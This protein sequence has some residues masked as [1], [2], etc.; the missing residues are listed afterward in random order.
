[1]KKLYLVFLLLIFSLLSNLNNSIF[2]QTALTAG[3]VAVVRINTDN[4]DEF[5]IVLLTAIELNTIINFTD[6]GWLP[7]TSMLRSGEGSF[8]WTADDGPYAAGTVLS[9]TRTGT[10]TWVVTLGDGSGSPGSISVFD[11]G[12]ALAGNGDQVLVYQGLDTNPD[13]IYAAQT[14]STVWQTGG[15]A[16]DPNRSGLPSG[17]TNGTHA[18]AFG[19]GSGNEDEYDNIT[20]DFSTTSGAK[21]TILAAIGNQANWTGRN[22]PRYTASI[23][24]FSVTVFPVEL[25]HFSVSLQG[26]NAILDWTT[27]TEINNDYFQ[28]ERAGSD[29]SF[30]P[31]GQISGAGNSS[32][33]LDYQFIDENPL[34]GSNFYRL[35]QVDFN[36]AFEIF[37]TVEISFEADGMLTF[38]SQYF[39]REDQLRISI[40]NPENTAYNME[41]LSLNGQQLFFQAGTP[42]LASE[43]LQ[44]SLSHLSAGMYLIRLNS[45]NGMLQYRK[46]MK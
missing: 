21:S 27:D 33:R 34:E 4:N 8:S 29:L 3:D 16:N 5:T 42:G 40:S 35:R 24:S 26:G 18:I 25:S 20:F 28:I 19:S 15:A 23:S 17:L 36:G 1:M 6:R 22:N 41:I 10:D 30:L 43:N 37:Q 12:M 31:I 7:N 13:F 11:T 44:I 45:T 38:S 9:F 32:N 2:A 46:F 39:P 14:N